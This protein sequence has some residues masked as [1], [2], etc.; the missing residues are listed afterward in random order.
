MKIEFKPQDLWVG[1]Y[2]KTENKSVTFTDFYPPVNIVVLNI[3]VCIIPMF[4]IKFTY[5]YEKK[6]A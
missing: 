1:V 3:W 4:P 2:W 6:N 5:Y